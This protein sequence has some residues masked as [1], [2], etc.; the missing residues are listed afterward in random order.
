MYFF[1]AHAE[2]IKYEF[3]TWLC[4]FY[5]KEEREQPIIK[6]ISFLKQPTRQRKENELS[7]RVRFIFMGKGVFIAVEGGLQKET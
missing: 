7:I 2:S 3:L 4:L 6:A 1:F 5:N